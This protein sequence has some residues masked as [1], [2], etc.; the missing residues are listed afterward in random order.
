MKYCSGPVAAVFSSEYLQRLVPSPRGPKSIG[1]LFA[2]HYFS[3][4]GPASYGYAGFGFPDVMFVDV[5]I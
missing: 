4:F 3:K 1:K 5:G 2:A